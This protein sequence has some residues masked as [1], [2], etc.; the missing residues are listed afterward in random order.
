MADVMS[1]PIG[2]VKT[3]LFR[4]RTLLKERLDALE[5]ARVEGVARAGELRAGI[6]ANLRT[7]LDQRLDY[8]GNGKGDGQ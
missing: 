5:R 1:V 2:T 8:A 4:A 7:V 6:E 3:Q